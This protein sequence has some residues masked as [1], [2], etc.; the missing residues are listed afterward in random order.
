MLPK[1]KQIDLI[2]NMPPASD[3]RGPY[4]YG[5]AAHG[6]DPQAHYAFTPDVTAPLPSQF[7]VPKHLP[8]A[9]AAPEEVDGMPAVPPPATPPPE[10]VKT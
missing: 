3:V 2:D 4:G 9:P 6:S 1:V 10:E 7:G 8:E 5:R